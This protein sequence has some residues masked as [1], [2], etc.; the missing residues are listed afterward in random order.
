MTL[1]G[2]STSATAGVT[3]TGPDKPKSV[4]QVSGKVRDDKGKAISGAQVI[5]QDSASHR[6]ETTSN[7]DGGFAFSSSDSK[8]I[9]VG[10]IQVGAGKDGYKAAASNVT[11]SAGKTVVVNLTLASVTASPS[12]TPSATEDASTPPEEETE[13][14]TEEASQ[15]GALNADK[16]AGDE[17]NGSLLFI[18]LGGLLVAAGIGAIVLVLMRRKNKGDDGDSD[19]VPGGGGPGPAGRGGAYGDQ[20]RVAAPV[21]ARNDATMVAG[22]GGLAGGG[23]ADAPTVLQRAVPPE[24]EFPDPYGVPAQQQPAYGGAGQYGSPTQTYGAPAAPVPAAGGYDEEYYDDGQQGGGY[25]GG[26]PQGGGA[27]QQ[28]YD[29]PTGMY[30]PEEYA[31]PG[32]Q[33][34]PVGGAYGH[35]GAPQQPQQYDGWDGGGQQAGN[36]GAGNG[37]DQGY[38]QQGGAGGYEQGGYDQ[39]YDQRGGA[40]YGGGGGY[41]SQQA[42]DGGGYDQGYDSGGGYDQRGGYEQP[43]GYY[44]G[45]QAGGPGGGPGGGQGDPGARRGGPPRQGPPPSEE[46]ARPGQRRL[47]WMDD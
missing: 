19:G 44:G 2:K 17:G 26:Q 43:G 25:Y 35:G 31:E 45:D 15:N 36:Y 27:A 37:Y 47:P 8:P 42:Y 28:R 41:Q 30:R 4:R 13:E 40:S 1:G 12:A 34:Q 38:Q 20:T 46:P 3:V 14:P 10:A 39:G 33:Q 11:G 23:M 18:I 16:T 9:A 21:G 5:M 24:D 32:Y 6:Y 29:E 7:G 22:A